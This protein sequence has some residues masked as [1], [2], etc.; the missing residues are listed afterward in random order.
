MASFKKPELLYD[1]KA[2]EPYIDTETM[3]VHHKK[4]HAAYVAGLEKLSTATPTNVDLHRLLAGL[5]KNDGLSEADKL[6]L[7]NFGGGHYNHSL[8]WMYMSPDSDE[9]KI[10]KLLGE[11][12]IMDFKSLD[13]FKNEFQ[14]AAVKVFGSGWC[15]WVFNTVQHKSFIMTTKD[16]INPVMEDENNICL[17]GLDVWEHAYYLKY[18]N[19]RPKYISNWWNVVNWELVSRIHDTI[20]IFKKPLAI[21][22]DGYIIFD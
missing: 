19:E 6:V 9:S 17:L 15:W 10:S 3:T 1:Y 11:R 13:N 8:F 7:T 14:S 5:F 4:H 20:A 16:Q 12:I 2:L 21:S 18:M 22:E